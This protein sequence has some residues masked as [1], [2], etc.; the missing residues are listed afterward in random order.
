MIIRAED[1][2]MIKLAGNPYHT[3]QLR[4]LSILQINNLQTIQCRLLS[5]S[6]HTKR[7]DEFI[8]IRYGVRYLLH[9]LSNTIDWMQ[10][11]FIFQIRLGNNNLG[12]VTNQSPKNLGEN[13]Q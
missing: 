9:S 11:L 4:G 5:L 6:K 10:P 3:V 7:K 1:D 13:S 8:N 12:E 2:P